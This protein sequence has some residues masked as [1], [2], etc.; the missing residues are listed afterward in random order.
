MQIKST[1]WVILSTKSQHPPRRRSPARRRPYYEK[2][3]ALAR[4]PRAGVYG[5]GATDAARVINERGVRAA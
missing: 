2:H 3:P 5:G 1:N 4:A